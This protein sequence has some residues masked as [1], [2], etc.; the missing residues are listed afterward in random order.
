MQNSKEDPEY[1]L[2]FG[3]Q[4][5][6]VGAFGAS[7]RQYRLD[8]WD[9]IWGY[10]GRTNK[11]A[12]QGDVLMPF[13]SRLKDGRY[14]FGGQT[15]QLELTDKEGPNAIHGFL[16]AQMWET[17]EAA[18]DRVRF[19]QTIRPGQYAGYPFALDLEIA[20]ALSADGLRTSFRARNPGDTSAPFGAGFHPYFTLDADG[21]DGW[22]AQI[23][24]AEYLE[25]ENLVPT[26][27]ILS[28]EDSPL[29][30]R[31]PKTVGPNRFNFCFQK[32]ARDADGYAVARLSQ[33]AGGR[34]ITLRFDQSFDYLV[35]Y[36]GEAI[37]APHARRAFAIEPLTCATDAFNHPEWGLRVLEPG[38][39]HAGHY[40]IAAAD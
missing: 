13:P 12:G 5:A 20:Y 9:V 29:D 16:R 27:R 18:P 22:T 38:Q 26:G 36:S 11:L 2:K 19:R 31:A 28:V 37:P 23:P 25:F 17:V 32:L 24:A 35:V 1:Q 10:Q 39:S 14:T 4:T 7:L 21:I 6:L 34:R 15:H 3:R 30:Y 33:A 8:D 40:D